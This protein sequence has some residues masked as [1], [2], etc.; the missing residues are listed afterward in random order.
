MLENLE[1][2]QNFSRKTRSENAYLIA[3]YNMKRGKISI[4]HQQEEHSYTTKCILKSTHF[5][6]ISGLNQ[7]F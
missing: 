3:L 2:E 1:I 7:Q 4:N 5:T 6:E